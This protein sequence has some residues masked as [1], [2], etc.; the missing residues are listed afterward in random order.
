M[1]MPGKNVGV[2]DDV[3]EA[4]KGSTWIIFE[5]PKWVEYKDELVVVA[6]CVKKKIETQR[7]LKKCR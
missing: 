7:R 2:R 4:A 1:S 3:I 6:K 5:E